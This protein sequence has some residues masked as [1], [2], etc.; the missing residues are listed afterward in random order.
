MFK[1]RPEP[2]PTPRPADQHW[3]RV[4]QLGTWLIM[5]ATF[6]DNEASRVGLANQIAQTGKDWEPFAISDALYPLKTALLKA[7]TDE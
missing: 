4:Y 1:R 2:E 3:L 6:A 5:E 7:P